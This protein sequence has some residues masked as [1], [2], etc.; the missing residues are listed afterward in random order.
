MAR[1][2]K[3]GGRRESKGEMPLPSED[4]GTILCVI[5]RNVGGGFLEVLCTDGNVYMARIPGKMRRRVW[6]REGDVVLFLPWGTSDN[7]GEVVY[8]YLRDEVRSLIEKGLITE[9]FLEEVVE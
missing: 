3:K 4:E 8:R 9:E 2:R 7:K 6:M 5:T 1:G